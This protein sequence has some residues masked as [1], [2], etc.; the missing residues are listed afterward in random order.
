MSRPDCRQRTTADVGQTADGEPLEYNLS[1]KIFLRIANL[2]K[3][4]AA[5]GA[6]HNQ[7]LKTNFILDIEMALALHNVSVILQNVKPDC[8]EYS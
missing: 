5:L 7:G 4:S 3:S 8:P 6:S 2:E 1:H